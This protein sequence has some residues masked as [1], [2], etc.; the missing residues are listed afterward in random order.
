MNDAREMRRNH[1]FALVGKVGIT[2]KRI[3]VDGHV[4]RA[5]DNGDRRLHV[6]DQTILE[7]VRDGETRADGPIDHC[8]LVRGG[9]AKTRVPC[10]GSQEP[11][12]MRGSGRCK[13]PHELLLSGRVWMGQTDGQP[14]LLLWVETT[15]QHRSGVPHGGWWFSGGRWSDYSLR[16]G[17]GCR[18]QHEQ[19]RHGTLHE[20]SSLASALRPQGI[21]RVPCDSM[22]IGLTICGVITT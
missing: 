10:V 16:L 21:P 7:A 15:H 14:E 11:A 6:H 4:Q 20:F 18:R 9:R 22:T 17:D 5:L 3:A 8:L 12:K 13:I 19:E 2:L 1:R